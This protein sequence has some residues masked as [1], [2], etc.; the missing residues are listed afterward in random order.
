MNLFFRQSSRAVLPGDADAADDR[1][2]DRFIE[3]RDEAA[4][5]I[6]AR[7]HG[8]MV[9][10]VCRRMLGSYQDAEDAF[11]ATFLV[12]VR[13]ARSIAPRI[14]VGNWL[15]GVAYQ[16]ACKARAQAAQRRARERQVT[17]MPE[18]AA[19][20]EPDSRHWQP[21]LDEALNCL[22]RKYQAPIVLCDLE[23]RSYK[24]AA[25]QLGWPEG[26]LSV[27]LMRARAMLARL[28]T[29]K[30]GAPLASGTVPGVLAEASAAARLPATLLSAT[31]QAA[32]LFAAGQAAAAGALSARV[33]ALTD[34]VLKA[35]FWA[36]LKAAALV[37]LLALLGAGVAVWVYG[38]IAADR[39]LAQGPV[40]PAPKTD[41][42]KLQGA[43]TLV[44]LNGQPLPPGQQRACQFTGDQ[45]HCTMFPKADQGFK[46]D[47]AKDPKQ[48]DLIAPGV[49]VARGIYRLAEG[50]LTICLA[51]DDDGSR[52]SRFDT[53]V[54]G[55][56]ILMVL[57][58][59]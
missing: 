53:D 58:K 59:Q 17:V 39:P 41:E 1:L 22:P 5:E 38:V 32:G 16:T 12:L 36:K 57:K 9:W 7:K 13:K 15:Y 48:I 34:A 45:F 33:A 8:P 6:L 40:A 10:G 44:A 46:L 24:E 28:L 2:L 11:Q 30:G 42:Q 18:P 3:R 4:F 19:G 14:Q 56:A 55:G 26:T 35:L 23:G 43:W 49:G 52:P 47:A 54:P 31:T 27:R 51:A 25:G 21:W 29:K 20:S 37:V 50:N